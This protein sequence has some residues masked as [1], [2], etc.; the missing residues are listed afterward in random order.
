MGTVSSIAVT[1]MTTDYFKNYSFSFDG[2]CTATFANGYQKSVTPTSVTS[3]DMSTSGVKTIT[4]SFTS[5]GKSVST[6][7]D[8]HVASN[9]VVEEVTYVDQYSPIGTVTYPSNT[10]TISVNTLSV[11]TS[12]YTTIEDNSIRLGSGSNT[13]TVTVTSTTSNITKVVVSAKSY[14]S[15]T[16]VEMTIAGS[17]N[18]LTSSYADYSKEFTTATNS[19]SIATTTNKKRSNIQTITVYKT[20]QVESKTDISKSEDCVG[21]ETFIDTYLHMN[22]TENLGYCNDSE[23]HYY[24]TA[25]AAFN[26]LNQ[27]QRSLFTS[28]SAYSIEFARLKAWA[29]ANGESFSASNLLSQ[30][31]TVFGIYESSYMEIGLIFICISTCFALTTTTLIIKR[32]R[33]R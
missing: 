9:R 8:I 1:G 21:L 23:H 18:T 7:Y 13:G 30:N 12:G 31:N 26:N 5:N 27:H 4:V 11:S 3:P 32:R 15:D 25:K 14:G 10:Q 19:V 29:K 24:S 20:I 22:Y 28:N 2:T 33:M 17:S 16:G 6:T